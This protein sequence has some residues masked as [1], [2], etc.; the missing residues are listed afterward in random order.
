[1]I[2]TRSVRGDGITTRYDKRVIRHINYETK[3]RAFVATG[4]ARRANIKYFIII[5][6][7]PAKTFLIV[8]NS[9]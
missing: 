7:T 3:P 1:M 8:M 5:I 9:N 2:F 4:A 6:N